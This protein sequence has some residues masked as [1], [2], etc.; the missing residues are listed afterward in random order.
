MLKPGQPV[1]ALTLKHQL[2]GRVEVKYQVLTHSGP[3]SLVTVN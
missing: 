3:D 1:L 2:Y